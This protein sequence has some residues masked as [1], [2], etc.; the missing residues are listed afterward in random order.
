L[1]YGALSVD[2]GRVD[3]AWSVSPDSVANLEMTWAEHGGPPVEPAGQRG[4]GS[5]VLEG[6]LAQDF[7]GEVSMDFRRDGLVC[8]LRG[9]L[10]EGS[11]LE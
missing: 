3:V 9:T 5:R 11:T 10:P 8:T 1:K 4:F 6:A 2:G 7:D